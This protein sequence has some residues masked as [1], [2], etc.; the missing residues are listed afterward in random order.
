M[1]PPTSTPH[2]QISTKENRISKLPKHNEKNRLKAINIQTM[3]IQTMSKVLECLL[4]WI[5]HYPA[6]LDKLVY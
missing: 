2:S 1:V 5:G 4:K 6:S 3:K